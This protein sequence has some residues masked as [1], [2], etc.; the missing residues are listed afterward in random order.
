MTINPLPK[1]SSLLRGRIYRLSTDIHT[2]TIHAERAYLEQAF[3]DQITEL[4]GYT[5]APEIQNKNFSA[6]LSCQLENLIKQ[7]FTTI[8]KS[9]NELESEFS[10]TRALWLLKDIICILISYRNKI[11]PTYLMSVSTDQIAELMSLLPHVWL[12]KQAQ[13][14]FK[15]TDLNDLEKIKTFQHFHRLGEKIHVLRSDAELPVYNHLK[16]G[17]REICTLL[18]FLEH[19]KQRRINRNRPKECLRTPKYSARCSSCLK[20]I[21]YDQKAVCIKDHQSSLPISGN[22][23]INKIIHGEDTAY[24]CN[25]A[26][27]NNLAILSAQQATPILE[28]NISK[29]KTIA[30]EL[31][32]LFST[33]L[34]D[35]E[36][37]EVKRCKTSIDDQINEFKRALKYYGQTPS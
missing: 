31:V 11:V 22:P 36:V 24:T 14:N 28:A 34:T 20:V 32:Q 27:A 33:E 19:C 6:E 26:H 5:F 18:A 9:I 29:L 37:K 4:E 2:P 13:Q 16:K 10:R 1:A 12:H 30:N 35:D 8:Y 17:L 21:R 23:K 15:Q 7:H 25:T 3:F